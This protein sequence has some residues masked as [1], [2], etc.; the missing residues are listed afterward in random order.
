MRLTLFALVLLA[1]AVGLGQVPGA[2]Q[3]PLTAHQIMDLVQAGVDSAR[4]AKAVEERGIDFEPSDEFIQTLKSKGATAELIDRLRNAS[5]PPLSREE[6]LRLL[7]KREDAQ[8]IE[9]L[10]GQRGLGFEASDQDFDTFRI[11]GA[12]EE[13]L[14]AIRTAKRV[15]TPAVKVPNLTAKMQAQSDLLGPPDL[16]LPQMQ[17]NQPRGDPQGV[18]GPPTSGPG[19]GAG[20]YS[21]GGDV[22]GPIAIYKPEP[23]YSEEAR[24][25]K[26]QGTVVLWIV[27]GADGSVSNVRVVKPLGLGLD[28]KAVE[29]VRTWKFKPCM[30]N[31]KPVP[32]N[33]SVEVGFHLTGPPPSLF[34]TTLA[35]A[36]CRTRVQIARSVADD[37]ANPT[38]VNEAS[39]E[40][41]IW[42]RKHISKLVRLCGS[43]SAADY[44]V[45]WS[46]ASYPAW[47]GVYHRQEND[48]MVPLRVFRKGS[49]VAAL[50]SALRFLRKLSAS[51][52]P[53]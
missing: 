17:A 50:A 5:L 37:Q 12:S 10:I 11:A 16:K 27:V 47:A 8:R 52:V 43:D 30:R 23:M 31:S 24:K 6:L 44:M 53:R 39:A 34:A 45:M 51:I 15:I 1:A 3:K 7:G 13:L 38:H 4:I 26:Y 48:K 41:L 22:S 36:P 20:P 9:W 29:T 19:T 25:A 14:R 42:I 33:V 46:T 21:I 18:W 49:D 32:C 28:E 40:Q 35:G 2:A